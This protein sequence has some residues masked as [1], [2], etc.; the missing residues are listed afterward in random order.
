MLTSSGSEDVSEAVTDHFGTGRLHLPSE[1][2]VHWYEGSGTLLT[3]VTTSG[4][5]LGTGNPPWKTH[6]RR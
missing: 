3:F 5:A 1:D 2:H 4:P 6:G